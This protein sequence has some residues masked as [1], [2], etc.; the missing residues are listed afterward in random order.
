[1]LFGAC[2]REIDAVVPYHPA[3]VKAQE[4]AGLRRVPVQIHHGTADGAVPITE[5]HKTEKLLKAQGT[6]VKVFLYAGADH[7][8]P[9]YTRS[10]LQTR[11]GK[12]RM[13]T[14]HTVLA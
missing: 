6:P 7:G 9:A 1:M 2:S 11:R 12:T 3:P 13:G 4:V 5:S 8:F 10:L 14:R